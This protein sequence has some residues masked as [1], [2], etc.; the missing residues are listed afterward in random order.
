MDSNDNKIYCMIMNQMKMMAIQ[1]IQ[2]WNKKSKLQFFKN[3]L[4]YG[5]LKKSLNLTLVVKFI[6]S[7]K[8]KVN[9][10]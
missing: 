9:L 1:E 5:E 2:E 7:Q 8:I 10:V 6:T 4:I 3:I